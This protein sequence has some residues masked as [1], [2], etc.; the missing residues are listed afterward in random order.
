MREC[1]RLEQNSPLFQKLAISTISGL[2][3]NFKKT[4][5]GEQDQPS[6][7]LAHDK[8]QEMKANLKSYLAMIKQLYEQTEQALAQGIDVRDGNYEAGV[9]VTDIEQM[10]DSIYNCAKEVARLLNLATFSDELI[11]R[12]KYVPSEFI[13]V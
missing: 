12:E 1:D 3:S 8:Y 2:I 5:A 4:Q 7:L 9:A 13:T 10:I 6:V 11:T